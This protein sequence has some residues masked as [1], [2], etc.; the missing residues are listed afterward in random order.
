MFCEESYLVVSKEN[1]VNYEQ[2]LEEHIA[3]LII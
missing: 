3:L 1:L 2:N